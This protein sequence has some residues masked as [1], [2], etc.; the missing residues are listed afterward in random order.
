MLVLDSILPER[1]FRLPCG[2]AVQ[3]GEYSRYQEGLAHGP[4]VTWFTGI[5]L[6]EL[7]CFN[8]ELAQAM[9]LSGVTSPAILK[10]RLG[11]VVP[12]GCRKL[13]IPGCWIPA[14]MPRTAAFPAKYENCR[15]LLSNHDSHGA[16]H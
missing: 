8:N 9:D 2:S 1:L 5:G 16:S 12:A 13:A 3:L 7:L 11:S 6:Q 14:A 4:A 10:H 15:D